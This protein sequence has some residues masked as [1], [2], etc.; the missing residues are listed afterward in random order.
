M[1][2]ELEFEFLNKH[3]DDR[4][5]KGRGREIS[6]RRPQYQPQDSPR[7]PQG[8]RILNP[9][10]GQGLSLIDHHCLYFHKYFLNIIV[11]SRLLSSQLFANK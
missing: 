2:N 8:G 11:A 6:T 5:A 9:C 10:C 3:D 1:R 7:V 4:D